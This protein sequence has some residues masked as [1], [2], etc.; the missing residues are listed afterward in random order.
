MLGT[1]GPNGEVVVALDKIVRAEQLPNALRCDALDAIGRITIPA[2]VP[3]VSPDQTIAAVGKF[4]V[5][6][7]QAEADRI[8]E[9]EEEQARLESEFGAGAFGAARSRARRP[10]PPPREE[11][12]RAGSRSRAG[13][14][15]GPRRGRRDEEPVEPEPRFDLAPEEEYVDPGADLVLSARRQLKYELG[16]VRAGI[17]AD[18]AKGIRA[19][20]GSGNAQAMVDQLDKQISDLLAAMDVEGLP[21]EDL[22]R[23]IEQRSQAMS[24]LLAG[25]P[26]SA[27]AASA[28]PA[29]AAPAPDENPF[30]L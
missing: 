11:P 24:G 4:A 21:P 15:R 30:G 20:A 2:Q 28:A 27:P 23:T 16:C 22:R 3:Q 9:W 6:T 5:A 19:M 8:K 18:P 14:R 12:P 26:P 1:P 7:C 17:S 29:E 10:P 25:G 13:E